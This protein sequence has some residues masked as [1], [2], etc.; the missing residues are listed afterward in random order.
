MIP[1]RISKCSNEKSLNESQS[2]CFSTSFWL[3]F[4]WYSFALS[5][6]SSTRTPIGFVLSWSRAISSRC[7]SSK[8]AASSSVTPWSSSL[9][10]KSSC[11]TNLTGCVLL[12][13]IRQTSSHARLRHF[14]S[15]FLY[16]MPNLGKSVHTSLS[17]ASPAAMY[18]SH[19]F[20]SFSIMQR[21]QLFVRMPC[22]PS[23][24]SYMPFLR[25]SPTS[26]G[27]V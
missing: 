8:K 22:P 18:K 13:N 19:R 10:P 12:K 17:D 7:T 23:S 11:S 14:C 9:S 6:Y 25:R 15:T 21:P 24:V 1:K 5:R 20:L 3:S 2:I 27:S 16:S 4:F 26:P